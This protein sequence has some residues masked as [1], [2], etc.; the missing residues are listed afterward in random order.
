MKVYQSGIIYWQWAE[1][2]FAHN[3]KGGFHKITH[4]NELSL[5]YVFK[6]CRIKDIC[7]VN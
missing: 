3:Y 7:I 2:Q 5:S 4:A 1:A 6:D